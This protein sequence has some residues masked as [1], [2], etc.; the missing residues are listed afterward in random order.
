[1]KNQTKFSVALLAL[2]VNQAIAADAKNDSEETKGIDFERIMVT[3]VPKGTSVM[4]S[5]V[6]TS[7]VSLDEIEVATPRTTAEIFR[8]MPGVRSEATGGEGNA[9]IAVR[10]LPVA[11]GGA[12]F[13]QLQED[14]LPV[15]QF[16]DI[17]FGNADI[18]LRAD[19]TVADVES[20]RGGSASTLASNAPGGIINL[21]SKTGL[22][23]EGSVTT[24]VGVDYDSIRTDFEFGGELNNSTY[25]HVG[26]F[27]RQG[28]GARDAG[29]T[30]NKGGQIKANLTKE[31][32]NGYVRLYFKHLDDKVISYLPMPVQGDGSSISG[33]D[34][35][36]DTPHSALFTSTLS[37]GKNG[38][39][40]TADM[41]DGMSPK[42]DAF[43]FESSFEL[44]NNWE[45]EN[46]FR[47]SKVSGG[48]VS[49]F[50]AEIGDS[51]AVAQS[52][53]GEGA[54]L[55]F[56]NGVNAGQT[57]NDDLVM[58]VHTFDV[59]MDDFD[60]M[61]NDL[62][63]TKTLGDTNVTFGYYAANQ[64]IGMSW[65]WNSYLLEVKGDNAALIN[66]VGEDGTQ[67][68]DNGLYAYGVP[69][70]GNCCQRNYD[71]EYQI[72]APYLA[73]TS[74]I[75]D[76]VIDASVRHDSGDASGNYAG[77]VQSEYDMNG[78]GQ[79]SIP[80]QS[81][82]NIDHANA[83]PINYDWDYTSY[84]VGANYQINK[85]MATFFRVSHGGRANAD[86]L[87][88]GKVNA[89]GSVAKQDAVD[90]VDQLEVGLKYR[91]DTLSVFA[92][93]F[94]AE[95]EE[96]NFEATS[97]KFF[98]RKYEATG[99]EVET[100]Y[101]VG[102]FDLRGSITLT[103]AEI[104]KDVISPDVVGNTPRR[105]P[106]LLYSLMARY[107]L[108]ESSFGVSLIGAT[109]SYAQDSNELEFDGYTQVNLFAS[110][111][112]AE[113]LTAS[114]N[115]NNAFD[116]EGITEAEEGSLPDNNIIRA[117]TLTGRTTSVSLRYQF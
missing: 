53:G 17:A 30:A 108:D 29:Y 11:S 76:W 16:G 13:L 74:S 5:S 44:G 111:Q 91:K 106:D 94:Y 83:S 107:N 48:F 58:R 101:Y 73:V 89:D 92:T 45:I 114:I 57:V 68:S 31:F 84:S 109:E 12:K 38:E 59:E 97:Q 35:L 79:I 85:D 66:V 61:V 23:E 2:V 22:D 43:G 33:F 41:R 39:L 50:P 20:I 93:A 25:F 46:R 42:V 34:S 27:V 80:E 21:I 90:E 8:L 105:Q 67:Y 36:S 60:N 40:R 99:L 81:V 112:L 72:T 4:S 56:A 96:Q 28:D 51:A 104:A 1:M 64:N 95:T 88:F 47:Y 9:N 63:L 37:R 75:G 52:I 113:N 19:S 55:V 54:S 65:L 82:S 6:S 100:T 115:I 7:S 62:K 71:A 69:Y 18:F 77:A 78:D 110:Y 87:L 15:L 70:W 103:D 24:T 98:D 117:R 116:A 102:N 3:G 26:G 86:R 49:P 32:D 10:G 14:G